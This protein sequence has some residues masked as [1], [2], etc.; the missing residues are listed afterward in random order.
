MIEPKSTKNAAV[1]AD[2]VLNRYQ[3]IVI[4]G[5]AGSTAALTELL[6]VFPLDYPLP[7]VV[8]QHLHP[9]QDGYF[10]ERFAH[11]CALTIT[12][13][14]D[15]ESLKAGYIYF[16]PPNYHLLIEEDKTFSLSID[17]RVNYVRPSIDVLFES[18]VDA[19]GAQLVGVILTGANHD[20]ARGLQL[21]KKRG[22]LT[23]VQDPSLAESATMPQAALAATPVDYSL[24]LPAIGR[25]LLELPKQE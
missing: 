22:G 13:A 18:A 12:E 24:S 17:E 19:Y 7:I 6:P 3:L 9:L 25:L 8:V 2:I 21:I 11:Q 15:K 4:G 14:Y 1:E 5:S 16:A 20:G 10:A 23:I